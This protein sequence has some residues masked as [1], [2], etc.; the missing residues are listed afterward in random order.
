MTEYLPRLE[1]IASAIEATRGPFTLFGLF[2]REDAGG[3]WEL[4]AAAPW[5]ERGKLVALGKLVEALSNELGTQ[6]FLGF[7]R[8]V[9]LNHDDPILKAIVKEV[10]SHGLPFAQQ[11]RQLFGLPLEEA[12]ILRAAMPRRKVP[13]TRTSVGVRRRTGTPRSQTRRRVRRVAKDT[14]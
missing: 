2:M 7:S 11:G 3:K 8:V 9:T 14:N 5:L 13:P 6:A 1:T 12:Y 4:V 10:R